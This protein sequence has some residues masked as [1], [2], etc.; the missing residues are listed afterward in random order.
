MITYKEAKPGKIEVR[1]NG[2]IAGAIRTFANGYRYRPRGSKVGYGDLFSSL[3]ACKRSL[4]SDGY[5]EQCKA[6]LTVT[7]YEF[8]FCTQCK[9]RLELA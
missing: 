4:E 5:C 2:K 6:S 3:G 9:K 1:L 8:G 7:D